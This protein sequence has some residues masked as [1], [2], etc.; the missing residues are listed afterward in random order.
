[1]KLPREHLKGH[2]GVSAVQLILA[3]ANILS[4]TL[5]NDY[6]EDLI[7]QAQFNNVADDFF[8]L[9]QVKTRTVQKSTDGRFK[10][11]LKISHLV[12]WISHSSDI[13]VCIYDIN[14]KDLYSFDP[15]IGFSLFDLYTSNKSY[16]SIYLC[17]E[18]LFDAHS[19]HKI[20]WKFRLRRLHERFLFLS[21]SIEKSKTKLKLNIYRTRSGLSCLF[22]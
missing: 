15:K 1:M 2:E 10:I 16:L 6:S 17:E 8:V 13:L 7:I 18:N 3:R 12:R 4:E 14:S 22:F 19:A 21:Y 11:K 5:K 9:I 20:L